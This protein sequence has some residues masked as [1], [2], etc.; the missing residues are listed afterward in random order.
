MEPPSSQQ[1]TPPIHHIMTVPEKIEL[2]A[3]GGYP[4]PQNPGPRQDTGYRTMRVPDKITL[5]SAGEVGAVR[6]EGREGEGDVGRQA[7]PVSGGIGRYY[8]PTQLVGE[9]CACVL[10][11]CWYMYM[12]KLM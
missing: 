1:Q 2:T 11:V 8:Q 10:C 5:E 9:A 3:T 7:A 12:Y 4:S 6:G